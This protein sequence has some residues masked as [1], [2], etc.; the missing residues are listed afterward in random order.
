MKRDMDLIRSIL[1]ALEGTESAGELQQF[2]VEGVADDLLSY[3]VKIL[4]QAGLI[5]A[6]DAS[7]VNDFKWSLL[8]NYFMT[9]NNQWV[10][11][12]TSP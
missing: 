9:I 2:S 11:P 8:Q 7:G 3:H 10:T 6:D 5:D 12:D 1:F 4:S